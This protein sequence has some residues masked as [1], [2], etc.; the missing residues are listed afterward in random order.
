MDLARL[1]EQK[2]IAMHLISRL[3]NLDLGPRDF[4]SGDL[5]F[6]LGSW[7]RR[8]RLLLRRSLLRRSRLL[9][10]RRRRS[11]DAS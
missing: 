2:L 4:L 11:S 9:L 10:R 3:N 7:L 6:F 1:V 8:S 5:L